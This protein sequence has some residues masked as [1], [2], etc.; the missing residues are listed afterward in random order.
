MC[1]LQVKLQAILKNRKVFGEE[2]YNLIEEHDCRL[3]VI[4]FVGLGWFVRGVVGAGNL[5]CNWAKF[6]IELGFNFSMSYFVLD[7]FMLGLFWEAR[8]YSCKFFLNNRIENLIYVTFVHIY[9]VLKIENH[10][11]HNQ[12]KFTIF[13]E[14][15]CVTSW[16]S[17]SNFLLKYISFFVLKKHMFL[18]ISIG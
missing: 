3:M 9:H 2:N 11:I 15:K 7:W 16:C 5:S 13:L 1:Q 14:N 4:N 10:H 8:L 18:L 12:K 6:F 17:K